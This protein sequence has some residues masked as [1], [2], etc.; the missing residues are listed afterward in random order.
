MVSRASQND[1]F[2]WAGGCFTNHSHFNLRIH[3]LLAAMAMGSI[4]WFKDPAQPSSV[5]SKITNKRK[6][7]LQLYI[8]GCPI[9]YI[10]FYSE[11][12]HWSSISSQ[13]LA[14]AIISREG[15]RGHWAV[16]CTSPQTFNVFLFTAFTTSIE[17]WLVGSLSWMSKSL[18][19]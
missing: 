5:I 15:G 7:T 13:V 1:Y 10:F 4:K 14:T 2:H 17:F 11:L 8:I 3:V 12:S 19:Q 6:T 16:Y 9:K 18:N